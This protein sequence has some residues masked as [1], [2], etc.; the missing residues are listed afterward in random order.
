MLL[1]HNNT[2]SQFLM[3]CL[4]FNLIFFVCHDE[5][6]WNVKYS[7]F[8]VPQHFLV[9]RRNGLT[10]EKT[11]QRDCWS[12]GRRGIWKFYNFITCI[13]GYNML[14][15]NV[16]CILNSGKSLTISELISTH[17][18]IAQNGYFDFYHSLVSPLLVNIIV[19]EDA[20]SSSLLLHI[21]NHKPKSHKAYVDQPR[22]QNS[23]TQHSFQIIFPETHKAQKYPI[24]HI[25]AM[26]NIY[27]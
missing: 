2:L 16:A 25:I 3:L 15:C 10:Q 26:Y 11:R 13:C 4:E 19:D 27:S 1:L 23:H 24:H 8:G 5:H 21:C 20:K 7:W 18:Q 12:C 14:H 22:S 6:L 9:N 17:L